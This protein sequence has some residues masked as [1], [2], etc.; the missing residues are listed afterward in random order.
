MPPR[1]GLAPATERRN[2][3]RGLIRLA[4]F[5]GS[6]DRLN[7]VIVGVAVGQALRVGVRSDG[8]FADHRIR[9]AV[10]G[11]PEY[12]IGRGVLL[13]APTQ[14]NARGRRAGGDSLPR[15]GCA[16]YESRPTQHDKRP[17]R[18]E[19]RLQIVAHIGRIA[20]PMAIENS[21]YGSGLKGDQS[22]RNSITRI[23]AAVGGR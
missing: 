17:G 6:I 20:I 4:H 12:V 7:D 16:A 8:S 2:G 10:C 3:D 19:R 11:T 1:G 15:Q 22:L 23:H 13:V 18:L 14:V 21:G 5:S 9:T